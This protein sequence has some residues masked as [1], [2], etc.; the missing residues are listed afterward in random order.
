M[1]W[2]EHAGN[3]LGSLKTLGAKRLVML[4]LAGLTVFLAVGI[5]SLYLNRPQYETLYTGLDA[6][7]VSRIGVVLK[8]VGIAFDVSPDGKTI[9]VQYGMTSRARM[10][11]AEK[12]LPRSSKAGY[13]L[14]D[15]MGSLGLT[16]FMQQVTLVRALEGEITRTIQLLAG[17][18][19]ARVH[20][21][22]PRRGSFRQT[23]SKPSA[24]VVIRTDSSYQFTSA[25]AIRNLVAAAVP[26]LSVDAVTV[27]NTDGSILASGEN[28]QAMAPQ[29]LARLELSAGKHIRQNIQ[30]TLIPYLGRG[31]FQTSVIVRLNTDKRKASETTFDPA[32]KVERSIREIKE[33]GAANNATPSTSASTQQDIPDQTNP[34]TAVQRRS[35]NKERKEKLVNYELNTKTVSTVSDGYLIK[36]ISIAVVINKKALKTISGHQPSQAELDAQQLK[37]ESL[38]AS[39]AGLDISRGDKIDISI[40]DFIENI[41]PLQPVPSVGFLEFLPKI[42]PNLINGLFFLGVTAI[43]VI[44]GLRPVVRTLKDITPPAGEQTSLPEAEAQAD[45]PQ[46]KSPDESSVQQDEGSVTS[47]IDDITGNI[48]Q[49]PMQRL[50]QMIEFDEKQAAAVLKN[51]IHEEAVT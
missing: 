13:E 21:V 35:E 47:L 40:V 16:S 43:V 2:R 8:E 10:L 48:S 33:K 18:K 17:V 31:N 49:L 27:L 41:E 32:S 23:G 19:A 25:E 51:W 42:I 3:L 7:D 45:V 1:N 9:K 29:R 37:L 36:K 6:Q 30:T 12:N 28:K 44:F 11:L 22:L 5:S 24:S 38:I 14:F 46:L 26:G 4:G 39:A 50:E 34:A 15:N 20:I